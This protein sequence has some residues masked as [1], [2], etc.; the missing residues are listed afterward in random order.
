M[1]I[2][3]EYLENYKNLLFS[4]F[5][6]VREERDNVLKKFVPIYFDK[7]NNES[8]KNVDNNKLANLNYNYK[9]PADLTSVIKYS[10]NSYT[11][12]LFNGKCDN[13]KDEN[14]EIKNIDSNDSKFFFN[15]KLA[16]TSDF[17]I[18]LNS[19]FLNCGVKII[20]SK[21]KNVDI[22]ILNIVLE[23][24]LTIFQKNLIICEEGSKVNFVE[25]YSNQNSSIHNIYNVFEVKKK[26]VLNQFVIQNNSKN[27]ELY[28][29]SYASCMKNSEYDQK[30]YNFSNGYVRNYHYSEL[31]EENSKVSHIGFFFINSDNVSDNKTYVR[32]LAENCQSN[33]IY[34][35]VLTDKSK[36]NYFSNTYVDKIAQKTEG[37][38][39]SN[40]ILL[41]KDSTY[42]SKPELRIFADD[43]K[44]SHG[45]T[46]GPID[47]NAI[48]YLRSRGISKNAAIKM[49]ISSFINDDLE[50]ISNEQI[51][52]IVTK[53]LNEF[54]DNIV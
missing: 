20:V 8:I 54:L 43:V 32:H 19:L 6:E 29:S 2:D 7:K 12:K 46:I 49:I 3:K 44:C 10:N 50:N 41:S 15:N 47:E 38:Q 37:Y 17:L 36:A 5:E 21:N 39:L 33:Q 40:G 35:G 23:D 51:K 13:F 1:Y 45:S 31:V 11:I 25:E 9:K 48:F 16:N 28:L 42:F 18:D 26:S 52:S 53:N 30:V 4:D 22:K 24:R 34:K 27:H 14:L